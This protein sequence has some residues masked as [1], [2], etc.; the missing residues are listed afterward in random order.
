MP[1]TFEQYIENIQRLNETPRA[2]RRIIFGPP[3]NFNWPRETYTLT[4]DNFAAFSALP[5]YDNVT[6][7]GRY[8]HL[9]IAPENYQQE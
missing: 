6:G 1:V 5:A 3:Q 9:V 4:Y 8:N 2:S 7:L